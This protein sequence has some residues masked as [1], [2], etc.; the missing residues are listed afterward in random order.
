MAEIRSTVVAIWF[1]THV[2][3]SEPAIRAEEAGRGGDSAVL[4]AGGVQA[5]GRAIWPILSK[6]SGKVHRHQRIAGQLQRAGRHG[7]HRIEIAFQQFDQ[8]F[9]AENGKRRG[10][11]VRLTGRCG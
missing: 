6:Q 7:Q 4:A 9:P 8:V 3:A 2:E 10:G 1:A 5:V 11:W